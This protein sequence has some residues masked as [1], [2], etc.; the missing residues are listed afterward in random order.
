MKFT[1]CERADLRIRLA[2]HRKSVRKFWLC[3]LAS[4]CDIV[5][6]KN[7][8]ISHRSVSSFMK[9]NENKDK[10]A[11][12]SFIFSNSPH[13]HLPSSLNFS[14]SILQMTLCPTRDIQ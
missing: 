13:V 3:K 7:V 8:L 4:T 12:D 9:L 11:P 14:N 5:D 10:F 2:T 1:P 6:S